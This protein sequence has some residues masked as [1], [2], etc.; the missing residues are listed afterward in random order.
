MSGRPRH[1]SDGRRLV[2]D[3]QHTVPGGKRALKRAAEIRQCD[4][5][6]KDEKS[7]SVGMSTPSKPTRPVRQSA[8]AI[9]SIA[10]SN[11]KMTVFAAA[12]LQ[13]EMRLRRAASC[14]SASV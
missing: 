9:K 8:A 7:A 5:R 13:P 1:F 12:A 3:V 11:S 4:H 10:R 6:P 14:A 2:E